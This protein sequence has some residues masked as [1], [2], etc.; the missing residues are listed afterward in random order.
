MERSMCVSRRKFV[1]GGLAAGAVAATG[2]PLVGCGNDVQPAP[3]AAQ[4]AVVAAPGDPRFGMVAVAAN[5]YEE[6]VAVGGAITLP[7]APPERDALPFAPP[8]AIIVVHRA[9]TEEP[10][11]VAFDSLCPHAGCPLGYSPGDQLVKCPCHGSR[12][13]TVADP[14]TGRCPGEVEHR[15]ARA[16]LTTYAVAAD[17]D[18]LWIDLRPPRSSGPSPA[19]LRL[20]DYPELESVGG[21]TVMVPDGGK[22][23]GRGPLIV[24]RKD[25]TTVIALDARCTHAGCTVAFNEKRD[26]LECPCHGSTFD[27]N[28]AVTH[29]PARAPLKR[30]P[31]QF[32]GIVIVIDTD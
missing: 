19:G 27:L 22:C 12:F 4:A 6:L 3:L 7:I 10:R 20:T 16:P 14:V 9:A 15:P 30:Y 32:D 2:L 29:E 24:I 5:G 18:Q 8:S 31:V 28:G 21:S 11:F 17:G 1:G 26:E 25:A 23:G 13:F